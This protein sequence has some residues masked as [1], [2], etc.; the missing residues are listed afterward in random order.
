MAN[1]GHRLLQMWELVDYLIVVDYF[2]RY[3]E[4]CALGKNKTASEVCRALKAK[5]SR[6]GIPE[7]IKSDNGPPFHS[8]EYLRFA[9]EWGFDVS[10]SSSKYPPSNG[11][12]ERAVQTVKEAF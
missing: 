6:H 7:K 9:N 2:S 5:F 12:A 1:L 3:I 10:H 11:K 8:D 4:V